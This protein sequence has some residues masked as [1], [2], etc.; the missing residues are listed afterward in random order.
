MVNY[1]V[2]DDEV[3]LLQAFRQL[4]GRQRQIFLDAME[5]LTKAQPNLRLVQPPP[6]PDP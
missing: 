5:A 6:N 1:K 3:T 4:T 2:N